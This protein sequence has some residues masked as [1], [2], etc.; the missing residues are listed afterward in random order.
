LD[1]KSGIL[2]TGAEVSILGTE[3][4]SEAGGRIVKSVQPISIKFGDGRRTVFGTEVKFGDTPMY[5]AD[6]GYIPDTLISAGDVADAGYSMTFEVL[7]SSERAYY[8][9][10]KG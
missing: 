6:H 8:R 1:A 2:D 7:F 5:I 3:Y 10:G 4:A 9:G